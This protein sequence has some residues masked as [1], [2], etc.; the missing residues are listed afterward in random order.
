MFQWFFGWLRNDSF[1]QCRRWCFALLGLTLPA[2]GAP[3]NLPVDEIA[4]G[5]F[6]IPAPLADATPENGGRVVNSGFLVGRDGVIVIDSGANH[7]HGEAILAT[8]ARVTPKPVK[9]LINTHSHPQNVLGNSAFAERGIPI[10]ATAATA[11]AMAE[12]CPN[13]LASLRQ[14]VGDEAMRATRI[15]LPDTTVA[16]SQVLDASGRQLRL[17][18]FGHGHTEGD[19]A[20]FDEGSATLFAGDLIYSGQIPHLSEA[21]TSGW[22][23]G[24]D[25]LAG[26]PIRILIPGRGPVGSAGDIA[27]IRRYLSELKQRVSVAY[28]EGRSADEAIR[29]AELQ[30]FSGWHGY[31]A[32]HGRNVQHVYFEIERL[33]LDGR[34]EGRQ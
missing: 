32:R 1:A 6:V 16:A 5:V 31:A 19:L 11:V 26:L 28:Q 10:L 20:V 34:R 22:I 24:L 9:M 33:D 30:E 12:R 25:Q 13:C 18:Q 4:D 8:V 29:L 15:Q 3:A 27:P 14:S 17:L 23:A 21:N 2:L 7:R